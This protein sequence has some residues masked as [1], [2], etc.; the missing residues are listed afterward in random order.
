MNE[1][2]CLLYKYLEILIAYFEKTKK[3]S[4][5]KSYIS[6]LR[7]VCAEIDRNY[8]FQSLKHSDV[9]CILND[10]QGEFVNST[11]NNRSIVFRELTKMATK[12]GYL[13]RDPMD[14]IKNLARDQTLENK[15]ILSKQDFRAIKATPTNQPS[16]KALALLNFL[17]GF[18]IQEIVALCWSDIDFKK[19]TISIRRARAL[20]CFTLPKTKQSKRTIKLSNEAMEVLLEQFERTGNLDSIDINVYDKS[21]TAYVKH[22]FRSV[23]IN[24][25]TEKPYMNSKNYASCFFTNFLV[26]A[27][28]EHR[29]PSQLRNS[30]ASMALSYGLPIKLVSTMMG[31]V[32]TTVTELHYASWVPESDSS[33]EEL[34]NNVL[35]V[36]DTPHNTQHSAKDTE[37]NT[38]KNGHPS[39]FGRCLQ[40][41]RET[42]F[43]FKRTKND[44]NFVGFEA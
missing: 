3:E 37:S 34:M 11:I 30:F 26:D 38:P 17:T 16:G 44:E 23:F 5:A 42:V 28:L 14:G 40:K 10:W 4:T 25:L 2:I 22:N 1:S 35:T 29:G 27:G 12:D 9:I 6:C 41:V 43:F 13:D 7:K 20:K 31:H 21:N 8:D 33:I 39:W 32:N 18:R 19:K 36:Q 24:D 15:K